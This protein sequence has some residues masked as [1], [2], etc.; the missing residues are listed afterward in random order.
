MTLV[1]SE[2]FITTVLPVTMA[3]LDMPVGWRSGSS[4]G[5]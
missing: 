2:G 4:R 5:L 1:N 3:A